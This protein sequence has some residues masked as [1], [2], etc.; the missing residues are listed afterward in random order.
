MNFMDLDQYIKLL[1]S[2]S[3]IE[4]IQATKA[5][6]NFNSDRSIKALIELLKDKNVEVRKC[7]AET[8]VKLGW[9]PSNKYEETIFLIAKKDWDTLSNFEEPDIESLL[10]ALRDNHVYARRCAALCLSKIDDP[11]LIKPLIEALDDHDSFVQKYIFEGLKNS[12]NQFIEQI[13]AG[14]LSHK[15]KGVREKAAKI[16]KSRNCVPKNFDDEL[17]LMFAEKEFVS[18]VN[19]GEEGIEKIRLALEDDD[20]EIVWLAIESLN[21]INN[22]DS[23]LAILKI[24]KEDKLNREKHV[25]IFLKPM[26]SVQIKDPFINCMLDEELEVRSICRQFLEKLNWKPVLERE[27]IIYYIAKENWSTVIKF[28]EKAVHF[29]LK[30]LECDSDLVRLNIIRL[31][32]E[33]GSTEAITKLIKCLYD[34]NLDIACESSIAL[35]KI[36]WKPETL[37]QEVEYAIASRN[38][39]LLRD[40]G[41][42]LIEPFSSLLTKDGNY[43]Q[44]KEILKILRGNNQFDTIKLLKIAT[45]DNDFWIRKLATDIIREKE[46]GIPI[47][48]DLQTEKIEIMKPTNKD[49]EKTIIKPTQID[50]LVKNLNDIN[51]DKRE[52]AA[53]KLIKQ[54]WKPKTVDEEV[55]LNIAIQNWSKIKDFGTKAIDSLT[56]ALH[57]DNVLIRRKIINIIGNFKNE[58]AKQVLLKALQDEDI[59]VRRIA[60]NALKEF[61]H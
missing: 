55:N 42:E 25:K 60:S 7:A 27:K 45:K 46:T 53:T 51:F 31:L 29:L 22:P 17:N 19:L 40:K 15:I 28:R 52:E 47:S 21:K 10:F 39:D 5:L 44:K 13:I 3:D 35:S 59:W 24:I 26:T 8:L 54:N 57:V 30:A 9:Q 34:E 61:A 18:L 32:G 14:F 50:T 6:V 1:N 38:W 11:S 48:E 56:Q 49:I 33:I 41:E 16:L 43:H 2:E 4:K 12:K 20:E 36:G 58:Q 37:K 23:I